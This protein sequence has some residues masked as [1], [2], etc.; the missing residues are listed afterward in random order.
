MPDSH[1]RLVGTTEAICGGEHSG[2]KGGGLVM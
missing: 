2:K 1:R